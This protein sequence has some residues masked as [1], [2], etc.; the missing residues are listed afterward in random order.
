VTYVIGVAG[1]LRTGLSEEG[2]LSGDLNGEWSQTPDYQGEG[3]PRR[4]TGLCKGPEVGALR[5]PGAEK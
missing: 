2:T 1:R 4:E 3:L 5:V